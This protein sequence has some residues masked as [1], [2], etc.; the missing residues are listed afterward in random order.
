MVSVGA[1]QLLA[2]G[3]YR[4][5]GA[6]LAEE[7]LVVVSLGG[8]ALARRGGLP[9]PWQHLLLAYRRWDLRGRPEAMALS[10]STQWAECRC[11]T[12][13]W[14]FAH[15]AAQVEALLELHGCGD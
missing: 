9:L 1:R 10:V 8:D 13:T 11:A 15:Q 2:D 14:P 3:T 4:V 12:L 5:G 6:R 7:S